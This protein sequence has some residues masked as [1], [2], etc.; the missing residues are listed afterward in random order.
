MTDLSAPPSRRPYRPPIG[1]PSRG[2]PR[3][4]ATAAALALHVLLVLLVLA[5]TLMVGRELLDY[6]QRGAGGPGPV[7]GGG[8]GNQSFPGRIKYVP[9]R[10]DFMKLETKAP[11]LKEV[12]VK[13]KPEEIKPPPPPP[14]PTPDPPTPTRDSAT[15]A[16]VR[17]DST[18]MQ[19][20]A[21][22]GTGND[23]TGGT[24]P[25]RGGG[26]GSG[27]GK[28]RG[29]ATGPGTGGGDGTVY[30]PT[31]VALPILPLPIP[32]KVR[33]YKMV[34]QFEVDSVGNATLLGFNP[35][36]DSGYNRRIRE[37]L[38]EIRFRPAVTID[39]RPVKAIAVVTAE[40]L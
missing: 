6:T 23:P 12:V 4:Q 19:V 5:P 29:S 32:G 2:E 38:L 36:R 20:G 7:G 30:P 14:P 39:G 35:S 16:A 1:I 37:M 28:G 18:S 9:E 33:P 24:G 17:V 11:V 22:R 10:V 26:E 13:P 21:G 34:A 8:G 27:I 31:V 40:A 3:A 25:G 15:A